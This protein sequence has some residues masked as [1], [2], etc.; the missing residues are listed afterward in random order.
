MLYFLQFLNGFFSNLFVGNVQ[1]EHAQ[2]RPSV[3]KA[4]REGEMPAVVFMRDV[5]LQGG[6]TMIQTPFRATTIFWLQLAAI[7]AVKS[8]SRDVLMI[9]A[10]YKL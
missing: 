2:K 4:Q 6:M 3:Q 1:I 7:P 10:K 8:V 9:I 5:L